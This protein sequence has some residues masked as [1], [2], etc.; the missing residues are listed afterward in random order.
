MIRSVIDLMASQ[1]KLENNKLTN[2]EAIAST[3]SYAPIKVAICFGFITRK[4]YFDFLKQNGN[5]IVDIK[6]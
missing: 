4:E 2:I 3:Y 5:E 1:N 6:N